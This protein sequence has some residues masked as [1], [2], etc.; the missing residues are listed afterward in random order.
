M[1]R[2]KQK[3]EKKPIKAPMECFVFHN[4]EAVAVKSDAFAAPRQGIDQ[5]VDK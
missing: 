3:R 1:L 5:A 4:S 2:A